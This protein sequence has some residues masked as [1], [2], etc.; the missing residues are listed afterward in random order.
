MDAD[1][2][3]TLARHRVGMESAAPWTADA[4][5]SLERDGFG[6][7]YIRQHQARVWFV[8]AAPPQALQAGFGLAPEV[9]FVLID[10]EVQARDLSAAREEVFQSDLRLDGNLMIVSDRGAEP[11]QSRLDRIGGHEQ[12]IAWCR[13]AGGWPTFSQV[14]R[15]TLPT[16][17]AYEERDAVRGAQLVGRATEVSALRTRVAR[18]DAVGLFGLRKMGKTS[19][20]RAVTDTFDP[21]SGM[22]HEQV[23]K[24]TGGDVA[25][26][27]DAGA[28]VDRTADGLATEMLR[29][30][31][32]RM[33]AA[34]EAEFSPA[35]GMAAWKSAVESL[36]DANRRVCVAIDEYDLLFEGENGEGPVERLNAFFR[37]ARAWAQMN[38]GRVS[39]VLVG[40][41]S[42]YLSQPEIDG[43]TS[44]LLAWSTPMWIGPLSE[45]KAGELLRKIGKRV[46][47][48]VEAESVRTAWQWAGGHPLLTRQFGSAL[49]SLVRARD[50]SWEAETDPFATEAI[51]R[52]RGRDAVQEVPRELLALLRKRHSDA[53][54][55]LS[56]IA[57]GFTWEEA[58]TVCGGAEGTAA[59]ALENMGVVRADHT[60][61][62]TFRWYL[63]TMA[64][65]SMRKAG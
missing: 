5:S 65:P 6:V 29:A 48:R 38:Q 54:G 45:A 49:R 63:Q 11:L 36:L 51:E 9:L 59:R 35:R 46:G 27:Y 34:G 52:Y 64:P 14:L 15:Q 20:L 19:V 31:S 10:G 62:E 22:R 30:L 12:R 42:N 21:A 23:A 43:V 25:V 40:R 55:L 57:E 60:L 37:L 26:V 39:L 4:L 41:D 18:G 61:P 58:I 44:A 17:D 33:R 16:F 32:R 47:L 28:L 56:D 50:A 53:F 3:A 7:G 8:R 24:A 13:A 1:K 2:Q